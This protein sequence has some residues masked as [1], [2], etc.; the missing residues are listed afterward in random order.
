MNIACHCSCFNELDIP[1][2][3]PARMATYCCP[4]DLPKDNTELDR[5]VQWFKERDADWLADALWL[6]YLKIVKRVYHT[7]D[8]EVAWE[9]RAAHA[10]KLPFAKIP[11]NGLPLPCN[12][13]P[14]SP[15]ADGIDHLS[16][17]PH[18]VRVSI[19][20]HLLLP[21]IREDIYG[22]TEIAGH[23]LNALALTSKGDRDEVEA[24]CSHSLLV[25]KHKA[26]QRRGYFSPGVDS[27]WVEWRKLPTYTAN[28]RMEYVFRSRTYCQFCGRR[29]E[30]WLRWWPGVLCCIFCE[31]VAFEELGRSRKNAWSY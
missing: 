14:K 28:A 2:N 5:L 9:L 21:E 22:I 7:D 17:L 27:P 31:G 19:L 13:L 24:F 30:K 8:S 3:F 18:D 4:L 11:T 6:R 23:A 12:I 16:A 29:G 10:S 15:P 1:S 20:S 25:W 26:E